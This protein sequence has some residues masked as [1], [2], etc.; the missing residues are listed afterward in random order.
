MWHLCLIYQICR[1][2]S[3]LFPAI[4]SSFGSRALD[5]LLPLFQALLLASG[6]PTPPLAIGSLIPLLLGTL[7]PAALL[8]FHPVPPTCLACI[9]TFLIYVFFLSTSDCLTYYIRAWQM[10]AHGPDPAP[11]PHHFCEF[12]F[13]GAQLHLFIYVLSTAAFLPRQQS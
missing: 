10:R 13:I 1:P 12:S 11:T 8:K 5:S 6:V 9:F 2:A 3:I 7:P 4:S